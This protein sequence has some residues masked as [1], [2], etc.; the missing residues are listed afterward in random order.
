MQTERSK[1]LE[2]VAAG[3]ITVEQAQQLLDAIGWGAPVPEAEEPGGAPWPR[4]EAR[5][6]SR[7]AGRSGVVPGFTT[8]ELIEL[9]DHGV[10]ADYIR[11]LWA[12]GVRDLSANDLTELFNHGVGAATLRSLRDA[13]LTDLTIDEVIE[14]TNHGVTADYIVQMRAAGYAHVGVDELVELYSHGVTP[15]YLREM[16]GARDRS[17]APSDGPDAPDAPDE[18]GDGA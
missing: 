10:G 12:A 17:A 7:S 18:D 2:M 8:E 9:A 14:L 4:R 16:E 3:T 5:E 15:A 13:G 6:R 1:V 11:D